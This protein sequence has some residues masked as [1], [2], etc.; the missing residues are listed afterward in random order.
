ME[1]FRT[2][3]RRS[4]RVGAIA[5]VTGG[6][7]G[8]GHFMT[9]RPP[10]A[11]A[12][13]FQ[14][15][16]DTLAEPG[17]PEYMRMRVEEGAIQ[18]V[19]LNDNT[20]HYAQYHT[21]KDLDALLDYYENLYDR[22]DRVIAPEAAKQALLKTVKGAKGREENRKRIEE[23]E[24]LLNQHHIRFQGQDWG[25]YAT[26]LTGH[27]GKADWT[28]SMVDGF[29]KFKQS[30]LV[31]DLGDPK[32]VVAFR[33]K[34]NGGSQYFTVWPGA[35]FDQRKVRARGEEDAPGYD[36]EDVDRPRESRRLVTF[37]QEHGGVEYTVLVYRGPGDM[38]D[39]L[40][41][42]I[43][44]MQIDGWSISS[45]FERGKSKMD[46]AAPSLLFSKDDREAYISVK[47]FE[48]EQGKGATT[49]VV[50]YDRG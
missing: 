26:I 3:A 16:G 18:Q 21:D 30:G 15:L 10:D 38:D 2:L 13:V 27:E 19:Y 22:P 7:F 1:I 32:I 31:K 36:V 42:Y 11:M 48:N 46:V 37:G 6:I 23:T 34:A 4:L 24:K 45:Q 14:D 33:D 49:T 8:F 44:S 29:R 28:K 9:P 43:E 35:D 50:L 39:T 17:M 41:G 12:T 40:D 47:P 20:L 25:G 5:A